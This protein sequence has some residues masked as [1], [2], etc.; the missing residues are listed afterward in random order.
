MKTGG[1][2][3]KAK[4]I[5]A[6]LL[7]GV[8]LICSWNSRG[9]FFGSFVILYMPVC[10]ISRFLWYRDIVRK[11]KAT[12]TQANSYSFLFYTSFHSIWELPRPTVLGTWVKKA[13][14]PCSVGFF[15]IN[16]L[17][18]VLVWFLQKGYSNRPCRKAL[19]SGVPDLQLDFSEKL[20]SLRVNRDR[21]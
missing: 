11:G 21:G 20:T 15:F 17:W 16:L 5:K 10:G 3:K 6:S 7:S 18:F 12:G 14:C 4:N 19:M 9:L 2:L 13:S 1:P 8:C